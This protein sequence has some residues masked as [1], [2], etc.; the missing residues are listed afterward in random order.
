ML[1]QRTLEA[2]LSFFVAKEASFQVAMSEVEVSSG[3]TFVM[4]NA[5]A[6]GIGRVKE[7]M[8]P[9][10]KKNHLQKCLGRGYV[11][12]QQ[13]TLLH[14]YTLQSSEF[15]LTMLHSYIMVY[16]YVIFIYKG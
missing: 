12:S 1:I 15:Q 2:G 8:P 4:P 16:F 7:L 9:W 13:G 3:P 10:E 14:C 6:T 11:S 5:G